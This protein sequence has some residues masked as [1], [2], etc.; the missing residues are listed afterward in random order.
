[1]ILHIPNYF[2]LEANAGGTARNLC[3]QLNPLTSVLSQKT[4]SAPMAQPRISPTSQQVLTSV[5]RNRSFPWDRHVGTFTARGRVPRLRKL[6]ASRCIANPQ[7]S[8]T[9]LSAGKQTKDTGTSEKRRMKGK[10]STMSGY[11]KAGL[12]VRIPPK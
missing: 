1:M 7:S 6:W 10:V 8:Q 9:I 12:W 4:Y 5:R 2:R 11:A 3:S